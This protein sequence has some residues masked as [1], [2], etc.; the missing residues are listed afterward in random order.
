MDTHRSILHTGPQ[1]SRPE[2][3]LIRAATKGDLSAFNTLAQTYQDVIFSLVYYLTPP[4][5]DP[6][7]A[8]QTVIQSLYRELPGYGGEV[9][10][11]WLYKQLV[12]VCREAWRSKKADTNGRKLWHKIDTKSI[13][14]K[15]SPTGDL[16]GIEGDYYGSQE[17][18]MD[19]LSDLPLEL[20]LVVVLVDIEGL[21]YEMAAEVLGWRKS[22]IRGRLGVARRH[23]C[24]SLLHDPHNL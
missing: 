8:A 15:P 12:K 9:F 23:L 22:D 3:D 2:S 20:R 16:V 11:I 19:L 5:D 1:N 21:N 14:P 13:H 24:Q 17:V 10:R 7:V 18:I 6:V 4:K